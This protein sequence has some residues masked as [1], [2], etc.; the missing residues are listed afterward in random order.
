MLR[1]ALAVAAA[2]TLVFAAPASAAPRW[3][4]GV[5][6]FEI[7]NVNCSSMI[8]GQPRLEAEVGVA[9]GQFV[10]DASPVVGEVFDI[11]LTVGVVGLTCAGTAPR[12][13]IALPPGVTPAVGAQHAIRCFLQSRTT[14]PVEPVT[15]AQGCPDTVRAGLTSHPAISNWIS[16]DPIP[17][18]QAAPLWMLPHGS[19][20]EVRVPVV[21]DRVMNG[22]A[23]A[24]GC[25]CVVASV[26]TLNGASRPDT[27]FTW[28]ASSPRSGAHQHLF[29]FP[30][31]PAAPAAQQPAGAA[32]PSL[33]FPAR[34]ARSA[35][36]ARGVRATLAGLQR[37]DTVTAR[38]LRGR[39]TVAQGRARAT[40]ASAS[41][42]VRALRS[43]V[44]RR[45]LGRAGAARVVVTV[46]RG[47]KT[48]ATLSRPV[49]L[50]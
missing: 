26:E 8:L 22:I 29:V 16:L 50:T 48:V 24:S 23:D 14:G 36:R 6:R 4:D 27:A 21:A 3:S 34:A 41:I 35:L 43:T 42:T 32:R 19:I 12:I 20:L 37:G 10:D 33:R 17:G 45:A 11:R 15:T 38:V 49:R 9:V 18:S 30:A 47:G 1:F 31:P 28:S 40:G 5:T 13:E 25:V 44:A 39:T 46:T 2:L 7:Q